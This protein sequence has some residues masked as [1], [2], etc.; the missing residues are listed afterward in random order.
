[1]KNSSF[2]GQELKNITEFLPPHGPAASF[3]Q[4]VTS[5]TLRSENKNEQGTT[6][7]RNL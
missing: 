3:F 1:M 4:I 6:K 5:R 2:I 7:K